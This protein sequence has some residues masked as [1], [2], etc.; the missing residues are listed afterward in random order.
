MTFEPLACKPSAWSL[1]P[2]ASGLWALKLS[3]YEAL[4]RNK[5][6]PPEVLLKS[7]SDF[8]GGNLLETVCFIKVLSKIGSKFRPPEVGTPPPRGT[9]P[10]RDPTPPTTEAGTDRYIYV[11]NANE[12]LLLANYR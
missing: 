11:T 5:S 4:K 3:S 8:R 7:E 1:E 10:L 6:S 9:P 2:L 12:P